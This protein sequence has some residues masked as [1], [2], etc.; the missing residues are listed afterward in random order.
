[1]IKFNSDDISRTFSNTYHWLKLKHGC[2]SRFGLYYE[3]FTSLSYTIEYKSFNF[4]LWILTKLQVCS[5][6]FQRKNS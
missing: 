3:M 1:M 2:K 5:F 4:L 6:V